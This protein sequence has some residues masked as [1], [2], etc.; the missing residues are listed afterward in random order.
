MKQH[1]S[2]HNLKLNTWSHNLCC[3]IWHNY[4]SLKVKHLTE[5]LNSIPVNNISVYPRMAKDTKY[6]LETVLA[7]VT[8]PPPHHTSSSLSLSSNFFGQNRFSATS[9]WKS[10]KR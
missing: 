7:V 6:K 5:T 4:L 3:T 1:K 8:R 10:F 2:F 9:I